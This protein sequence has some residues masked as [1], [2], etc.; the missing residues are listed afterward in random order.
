MRLLYLESY[1]LS[2]KSSEFDSRGTIACCKVDSKS[3][4]SDKFP[5]VNKELIMT[6]LSSTMTDIFVALLPLSVGFLPKQS[7]P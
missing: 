4:T 2:A 6:P 3:V 7:L 1:H 5:G